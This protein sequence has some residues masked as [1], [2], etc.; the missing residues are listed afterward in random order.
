MEGRTRQT[1]EG[2]LDA[3]TRLLLYRI[4]NK[5]SF[6]REVG[7]VVKTGKESNVY[8]APGVGA[9][10]RKEKSLPLALRSSSLPVDIR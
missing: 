3:R 6:F 5:G 8:Y 4:L 9:R 1:Q 7:G 2:V 10:G